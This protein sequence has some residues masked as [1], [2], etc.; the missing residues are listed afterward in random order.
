M[1]SNKNFSNYVS[2]IDCF[3]QDYDKKHPE[4]SKSQQKEIAKLKRIY[5]LRDDKNAGDLSSE[6]WDEF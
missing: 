3:L 4:L 2:D 1:G 6:L 5:R